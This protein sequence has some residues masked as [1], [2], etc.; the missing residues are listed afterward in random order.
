VLLAFLVAAL[1]AGVS[2]ASAGYLHS[3]PSESF[4][5]DGTSSS[6][7]KPE[8][9]GIAIDQARH[10]LYGF[11]NED[12]FNHDPTFPRLYG[13]DISGPG[14]HTPL[15]GFPIGVPEAGI[16]NPSLAVDNSAGSLGYIY[17]VSYSQSVGIS[18]FTSSGAPRAGFPVSGSRGAVDSDGHLWTAGNFSLMEYSSAGDLLDTVN[19]FAQ[20]DP[21]RITID[22]STDELYVSS[23]LDQGKIWKYSAADEYRSGSPFLTGYAAGLVFDTADRLLYVIG[24]ESVVAYNRDGAKVE[25][26]G[27]LGNQLHSGAID[28]STGTI[29]VSQAP[30]SGGKINVFPAVIV[31]D[32]T[33]GEPVGDA[34][35]SGHVDPAGGGDVTTCSFQFGVSK[36]YGSSAPCAPTI[37]PDYSGPID[38]SAELPSLVPE[39]TY[40]YRLT[41]G[42]ANGV[43]IGL[44]RTV[45]PHHVHQI[46]TEEASGIDRT[47]ATLHGS[48]DGSNDDTHYY[49]EWGTTVDYGETSATPPGADA[50]ATTGHTPL[51]FEATGLQPDTTY[52]YRV[53]GVN[54]GG[55]SF[56]DDRTFTTLPAVQ[57]IRT[58]PASAVAPHGATLN[59]S[60]AGTNEDTHYHFEWG[61]TK[62]YG[63]QTD[64]EDAGVTAAD[65]PLSAALT[66]L[67][68]ETT[69]H[70]RVVATNDLG[71]SYGA[72]RSFT[73]LPAV[74][75]VSTDPASPISLQRVTL[76]GSFDGNGDA[77][78]FY[79]DWGPT[80]A[81]G[82]QTAAPPGDGAGTP[83][84][85]TAV[86]ADVTDFVGYSTYHYRLVATN[87]LGTTYGPD[88][89]FTSAAALVPGIDSSGFSS[90]T[91]TSATLEASITP[92][93]WQTVFLFE[94]GPTSR[95]GSS[96]LISDPI[97]AD[98]ASYPVSAGLGGLS[99]GVAYHFRVVAIN[100]A[101]PAYGPDRT[102][103]TP[104]A[105]D[106]ISATSSAIGQ[107]SARLGALVA[108]N[109]SP[110][111][112]H[113][114]YGPSTAYGQRTAEI[115]VGVDLLPRE[116]AADIGGL[117]PGTTYHFRAVA[118]NAIATSTGADIAF[119]TQSA[120]GAAGK[121][122]KCKKGSVR[123][124]GK[125]VKKHKGNHKHRRRDGK[126]HG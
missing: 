71:T 77:T 26:I 74:A 99:P 86:S 91:P 65:T 125:C 75:G 109:A 9:A 55:T 19:T 117:A 95:Y 58:D 82:N 84:G 98:L 20:G 60:F 97:G 113:F 54:S 21:D 92:N 96:T 7:F 67:Q 69:Y 24:N 61:T 31:P 112:M 104:D 10:R 18:S 56:A 119:A 93:R 35:V 87:S 105:P 8:I 115:P 90:V 48:F 124:R 15:S 59:A 41:A 37:P 28:E 14:M 126:R 73:T 12:V 83:S 23:T 70:F 66:G 76:N 25:T 43:N 13:Y 36:S 80:T 68:L 46:K 100:F 123:R 62:S 29:Y 42:N 114:E 122:G 107:N 94:Y 38:V 53:V 108:A 4:G 81:Y 49:F 118:S 30:V 34:T 1:T 33:T 78:S 101:G 40:H 16:Q 79:F 2:S 11:N 63:S 103:T 111:S 120:P 22:L 72:D 110:T 45:T 51:S 57:E 39:T 50:G 6:T 102:F 121:P 116:A 52:H 3:F 106:V 85:P 89:T 64:E 44:D 5:P 27:G 88:R 17:S 32:P 47:T